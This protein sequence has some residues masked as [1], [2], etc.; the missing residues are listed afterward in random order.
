[1]PELC[2]QFDMM[3]HHDMD[4]QQCPGVSNWRAA[5]DVATIDQAPAK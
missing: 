1:L 3:Y 4:L 2:V 5:S